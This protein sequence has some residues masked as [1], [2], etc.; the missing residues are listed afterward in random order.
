MPVRSVQLSGGSCSG[1]IPSVLIRAC[2]THHLSTIAHL[3]ENPPGAYPSR[4]VLGVVVS[5]GSY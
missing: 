3:E 2:S 5:R 4:Y 1:S